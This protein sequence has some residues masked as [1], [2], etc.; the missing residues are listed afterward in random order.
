MYNAQ[1]EEYTVIKFVTSIKTS[2]LKNETSVTS[3]NGY[4]I[5][6]WKFSEYIQQLVMCQ[7]VNTILYH[8]FSTN[9]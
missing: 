1:E 8:I 3:P 7:S 2:T 5:N 6:I 4:P 9:A